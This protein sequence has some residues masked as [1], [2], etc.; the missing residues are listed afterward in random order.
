M[1]R[2]SVSDATVDTGQTVAFSATA[3]HPGIPAYFTD[4]DWDFDSDGDT[5]RHRREPDARL[6]GR[7]ELRRPRHG[8]GRRP[9]VDTAVAKVAVNVAQ[10][11]RPCHPA[12][13]AGRRS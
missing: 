9:G 3:T 10:R 2:A 4:F 8:D 13:D 11:R 6:P 5:G 1:A 7:G 12:A